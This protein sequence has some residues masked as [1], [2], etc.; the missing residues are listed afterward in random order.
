MRDHVLLDTRTAYASA[1]LNTNFGVPS[2]ARGGVI[3][4][5]ISAVAGNTP[6]ADLKLQYYDKSAND[7][8]DIPG[9]VFV[10]KTAAAHQALVVYPGV[11]E[12]ANVSVSDVLPSIVRAVFVFDRTTGDETYTFT[13]SADWLT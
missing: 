3:Y 5:D 6:I 8:L 11:A 9:A 13:L 2:W 12:T 1:T 4:W 7:Y 10:Q